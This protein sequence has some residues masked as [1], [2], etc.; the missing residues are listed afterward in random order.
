MANLRCFLRNAGVKIRNFVNSKIIM[1]NS[2]TNP[3]ENDS[4]VNVE[5]KELIE[6]IFLMLGLNSYDNK[7]LRV[8]GET[9]KYPNE[10]PIRNNKVK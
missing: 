7:K 8:M 2:K 1:G 5:T 9:T 4:M 6:I 10:I 3:I